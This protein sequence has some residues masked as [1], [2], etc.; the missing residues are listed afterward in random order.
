MPAYFSKLRMDGTPSRKVK[1]KW[2]EYVKTDQMHS[3]EMENTWG[4]LKN[5]KSK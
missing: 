2:T 1:D 3:K 5:L 4:Q